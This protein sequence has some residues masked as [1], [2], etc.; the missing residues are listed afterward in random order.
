ML[1]L[2]VDVSASRGLDLVL[3]DER[4]R[5]VGAPLRKQSPDDLRRLL[6]QSAPDVVAIDAPPCLGTTGGSRACERRLL[7]LGLHCYFTPSDARVLERP[8]YAWMRTGFAAFEAATAAGY[9]RFDGA[10]PPRRAAIEV[11]PHGTAVALDG[12]LPPPRTCRDGARKRAWRVRVLER[13]HVDTG[14][15]RSLDQV[16]AALAALTGLRALAGEF[17]TVGDASD[18]FIVL[19]GTARGERFVHLPP[20]RS[21]VV[22]RGRGC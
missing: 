1:A 5:L 20:L 4:R 17:W 3:L 7:A 16:D 9:A 8:F 2:G 13:S 22:G 10:S 12:A 19:P 14:E 21:P 11:F 15:L 18:G 6:E